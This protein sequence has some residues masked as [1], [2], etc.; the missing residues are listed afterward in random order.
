MHVVIEPS[1]YKDQDAV[2]LRTELLQAQLIPR[3]GSS[4]CSLRWLPSGVELLRQGPG[5]RYRLEPYGGSFVAGERAGFDEMLPTIDACF[6]DQPP[7]Q[8]IQM[9]DHGELWS[10]PWE[11]Q[12]GEREI[13]FRVWGIRFPYRLEKRLRFVDAGTLRQVPYFAFLP[14]EGGA[15][16]LSELFLEPCTSSYDRPD[17]ARLHRELSI[18]PA[19][20]EYVWHLEIAVRQ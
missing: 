16:G 18:L 10:I 3:V 1:R 14:N 5:E 12:V 13:V 8:G 15:D 9:P 7:W 19:R 2:T 20:G 4:M 11:H 6:C 17:L